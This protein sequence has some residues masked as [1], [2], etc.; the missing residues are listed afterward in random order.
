MFFWKENMLE[1][2]AFIQKLNIKLWNSNNLVCFKN[3]ITADVGKL[4][5]STQGDVKRFKEQLLA[6]AESNISQG[7]PHS[8]SSLTFF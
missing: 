7:P 8:L 4:I 5:L 3:M 1:I 2:N 6:F